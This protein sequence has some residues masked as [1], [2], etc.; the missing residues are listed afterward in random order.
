MRGSPPPTDAGERRDERR[1]EGQEAAAISG[2]QQREVGLE[3]YCLPATPQI[4]REEGPNGPRSDPPLPADSYCAQLMGLANEHGLISNPYGWL[5][6][7]LY[8]LV[9]LFSAIIRIRLY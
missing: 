8:H 6:C 1:R 3:P 5:A 2:A 7:Y 9:D 4:G